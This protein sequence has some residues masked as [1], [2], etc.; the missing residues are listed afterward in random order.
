[1]SMLHII[2]G[3]NELQQN[4]T[5]NPRRKGGMARRTTHLASTSNLVGQGIVD[6]LNEFTNWWTQWAP[7]L[8]HHW[9]SWHS[10]AS[11]CNAVTLWGKKLK[12]FK[13]N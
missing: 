2:D 11:I 8:E 5:L 1:M 10:L 6:L 12:A 3:L 4:F 13:E 7:H 9:S